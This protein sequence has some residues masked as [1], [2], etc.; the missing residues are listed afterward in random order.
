MINITVFGTERKLHVLNKQVRGKIF[1][2]YYLT[3]EDAAYE[4][5]EMGIVVQ[6]S[7]KEFSS[8]SKGQNV[9]SKLC[10]T[11]NNRHMYTL[12]QAL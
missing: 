4:N 9:L 1:P 8:V 3:V 6:V 7:K 5:E 11:P 10:C 2:K 12:I